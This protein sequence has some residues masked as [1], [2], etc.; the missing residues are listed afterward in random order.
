[1]CE[2]FVFFDLYVGIG[3]YDDIFGLLCCYGYMLK[4]VQ[5]VGEVM[6][7]IGLVVVGLGVLIFLVF[8]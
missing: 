4:I 6:M 2:F 5:E 3:L 1:M 7:I 8:F